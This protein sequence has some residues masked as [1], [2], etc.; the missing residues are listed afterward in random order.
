MRSGE[1]R[2]RRVINPRAM[3]RTP[4]NS[5][6]WVRRNPE[7][8]A[9]VDFPFREFRAERPD[10]PRALAFP[11]DLGCLAPAAL[12]DREDEFFLVRKEPPVGGL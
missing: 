6:R 8:P 11:P 7:G 3:R 2:L 5:G 4:S 1:I 10:A 9:E 12:L